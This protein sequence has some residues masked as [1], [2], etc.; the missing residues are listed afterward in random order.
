MKEV[1]KANKASA[2]V[3][4]AWIKQSGVCMAWID[5]SGSQ[6]NTQRPTVSLNLENLE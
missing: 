4:M 6:Q 1:R 3:C 2:G 5:Q